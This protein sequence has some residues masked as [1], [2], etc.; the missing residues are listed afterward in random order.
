MQNKHT[1]ERTS[2]HSSTQLNP[3][4]RIVHGRSNPTLGTPQRTPTGDGAPLYL[5]IPLRTHPT[6]R[7]TIASA[8]LLTLG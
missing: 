1:C 3:W 5:Y 8:R 4:S 7:L 2:T 6:G